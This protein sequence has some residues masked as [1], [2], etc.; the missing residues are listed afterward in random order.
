L[1]VFCIILLVF[2]PILLSL[3]K[4]LVLFAPILISWRDA[5]EF[6]RVIFNIFQG[7]GHPQ[8]YR[9]NLANLS[10]TQ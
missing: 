4:V 5:H 2:D 8:V 9:K 7:V 3:D 10:A 1:G 6:N